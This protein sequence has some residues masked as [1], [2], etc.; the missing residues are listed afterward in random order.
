MARSASHAC[1]ISMQLCLACTHAHIATSG[2]L[3]LLQMVASRKKSTQAAGRM[4]LKRSCSSGATS[5]AAANSCHVWTWA[6][7]TAELCQGVMVLHAVQLLAHL[8]GQQR[9]LHASTGV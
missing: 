9:S 2:M 3:A 5:S 1:H 6:C 8:L 7:L 4:Q